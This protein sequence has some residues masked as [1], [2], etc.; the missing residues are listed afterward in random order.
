MQKTL[1]L[2][3]TGGIGSG[4]STVAQMFVAHGAALIDADQIARA[5]TGPGGAA[6]AAIAQTFGPEYVA[7]DGAM[8]RERMRR[9]AFSD[10]TARARLEAIVHPCVTQENERRARDAIAQ[11]SA[12]LV[13]DVPLLVESGHWERRLDAVLVVDCKVETQ[14]QRVMTRN[15]LERAAVEAIIAAQATRAARRGAADAVIY[16]DEGVSLVELQQQVAQTLQ[17]L[18]L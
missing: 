9:L 2:G 15:G 10:P 7:S 13:F 3:L 12:L 17:Y 18:G 16:N 11:G 1:R 5:V 6:M 4:K 14:V 8:D